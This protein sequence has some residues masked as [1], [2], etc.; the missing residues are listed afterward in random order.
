MTENA[1]CPC[2]LPLVAEVDVLPR[3]S[4][5]PVKTYIVHG[6]DGPARTLATVIRDRLGWTAEVAQ[7]GDAVSLPV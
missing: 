4:S 2:A 7:G 5:A 3:L 6:E 1:R